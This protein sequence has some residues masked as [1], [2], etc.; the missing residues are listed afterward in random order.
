MQAVNSNTI[1]V[2]EKP[3]SPYSIS[4]LPPPAAPQQ[5]YI[6]YFTAIINGEISGAGDLSSLENNLVV[7]KI[8]EAAMRSAKEGRKISL[9]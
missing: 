9:K 1:R 5:D 7:V 4:Q 2:K 3:N 8:L 6:P